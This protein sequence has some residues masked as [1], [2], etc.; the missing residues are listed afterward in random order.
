MDQPSVPFEFR[1]TE[2]ASVRFEKEFP[3]KLSAQGQ[4]QEERFSWEVIKWSAIDQSRIEPI[5]GGLVSSWESPFVQLFSGEKVDAPSAALPLVLFYPAHRAWTPVA[6]NAID[7]LNQ[8]VSRMDSLQDFTDASANV[9]ALIHW[10]TVRSLERLQTA[11]ERGVGFDA[12]NDDELAYAS[13]ALQ[14]VL[15]E[16]H[17]VKY[18]MKRQSVVVQWG[19]DPKAAEPTLFEHLS[20]GQRT[21]LALVLDIVRRMLTMNGHLRERATRETPGLILIDEIETH[22]HPRWQREITTGLQRAFPAVQFVVTTHSPQVLS[23]LRAEQII[24]L[25]PGATETSHPDRAMGLSSNEILEE[26]MDGSSRN[27]EIAQLIRDIENALEDE[28][29]VKAKTDLEKLKSKVGE[30]PEVLRLDETLKWLN[31]PSQGQA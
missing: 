6:T 4:L 20:D 13:A 14:A 12:V 2:A 27:A 8:R 18:D 22:L 31:P 25:Q 5:Q 3:V 28:E 21:V 29:L 24:L 15:P 17:A 9:Q 26:V 11:T 1:N 10:I 16:C 19:A 23:E 30:I 7:A